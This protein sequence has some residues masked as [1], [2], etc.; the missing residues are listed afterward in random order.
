MHFR[1]WF[2][3]FCVIRVFFFLYTIFNS[4]YLFQKK[5]RVSDISKTLAN[6]RMVIES[7]QI[8]ESKSLT[9]FQCREMQCRRKS[10]R[11]KE[12]ETNERE[13]RE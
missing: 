10:S 4:F 9:V 6:K 3:E 1:V 13:I 7:K 5:V 8:Q 2:Q 12:P 11:S